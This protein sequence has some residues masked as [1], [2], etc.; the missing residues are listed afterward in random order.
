MAYHRQTRVDKIKNIISYMKKEKKTMYHLMR[1]YFNSND[2][3][4]AIT[5]MIADDFLK[6]GEIVR[7]GHTV[8]MED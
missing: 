1:P 5:A 7:S 2:M 4:R 8:I 3:D 6:E